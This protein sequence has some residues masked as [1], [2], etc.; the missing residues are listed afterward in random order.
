MCIVPDMDYHHIP[1]WHLRNFC[2]VESDP[3][4]EDEPTVLTDREVR[5]CVC[6]KR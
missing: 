2:N 5:V 3:Y 1:E 6:V 4:M